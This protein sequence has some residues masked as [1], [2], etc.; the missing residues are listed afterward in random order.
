VINRPRLA[1][2]LCACAALAWAACASAAADS[3]SSATQ[4][5][6]TSAP[7]EVKVMVVNMFALEAKPWI[8]AL[9]PGRDITVPGLFR[10]YPVVHCT[11]DNVCQLTTGMG[12]ANAA[13]SIMALIASEQFDLRHTYFVVA[14]IAGI[15]PRHGTLGSA[16]WAHYAVDSGIAHEIDARDLPPHWQDSY[17]GLLADSPQEYPKLAYGTEVF[18]LNDVLVQHALRLARGV[19]LQ[20]S[21]D[22][23]AYRQHYREDAARQAPTIVAC[24]TLTDDTWWSG[25]HLGEHARRW[26]KLLTHGEAEYCTTQSEDNATLTA[27]QRGAQSGLVDMQRVAVLRSA[28]DFDRPYPKQS[29][30]DSM[31]AQRKLPGAWRTATNN[32]VRAAMPL[33][34]EISTNWDQWRDGV[35]ATGNATENN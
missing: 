5:A 12:H 17:F 7:V 4:A 35:P 14:G 26:T 16:A 15:D 19:T 20:D 31:L 30:L 8:E 24:D 34:Q 13:A 3:A 6:D 28:S 22:I 18:T 2:V 21:D 10:E 11:D 29:A 1:R 23:R 25:H 27:L 9:H 33:V 32:L